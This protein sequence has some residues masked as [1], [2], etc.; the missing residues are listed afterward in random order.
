MR[1]AAGYWLAVPGKAA[2]LR[3]LTLSETLS[4][5]KSSVVAHQKAA[6]C[7]WYEGEFAEAAL[8]YQKAAQMECASECLRRLRQFAE[9][10]K[11]RPSVQPEWLAEI[12]G[13][14]EATAQ[15][16]LAA[17]EFADA[18]H[19]LFGIEAALRAKPGENA[20]T[21]EA[22]RISRLLTEVVK[23]GRAAL[24]GEVRATQAQPGAEVFKRWSLLEEAA[25]NYL[26]AGVQAEM[27]GDH[28]GAALL[29]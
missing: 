14:I 17:K 18:A 20:L 27:A 22:D 7:L 13:E 24:D 1:S 11:L 4:D 19:M 2:A 10:I 8:H 23:T 9:A 12:R 5:F 15:R 21:S 28:F 26:E 25:G 3:A 29:F 6:E 16:H